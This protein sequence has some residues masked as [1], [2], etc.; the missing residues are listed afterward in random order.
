R[1][2][3]QRGKSDVPLRAH[4]ASGYDGMDDEQD[5][6]R[7]NELV[8]NLVMAQIIIRGVQQD[9]RSHDQDHLGSEEIGRHE[10]PLCMRSDSSYAKRSAT[11]T[12]RRAEPR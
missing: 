6:Q 3:H 1:D 12:R 11:A 2:E 8:A 7:E 4:P 10:L 5:G 9:R